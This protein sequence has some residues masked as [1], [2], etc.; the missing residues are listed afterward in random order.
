[1]YVISRKF[2]PRANLL[3]SSQGAYLYH[4]LLLMLLLFSLSF[5]LTV[6][7]KPLLYCIAFI[8][9]HC[10]ALRCVVL[11]CVVLCCVVLYC[12]VLYCIRSISPR[13]VQLSPMGSELSWGLLAGQ[14]ESQKFLCPNMEGLCAVLKSAGKMRVQC[15][16]K[17]YSS[18]WSSFMVL[19]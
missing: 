6:L 13:S 9:L 4:M 19:R 2:P 16:S 1:M 5:Y 10:V 15:L 12:I 11:C 8:A 14:S 18:V 17:M 7:N 3:T